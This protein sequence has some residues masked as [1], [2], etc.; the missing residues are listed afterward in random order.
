[1]YLSI[2]VSVLYKSYSPYKIEK[3]GQQ[4]IL[5]ILVDYRLVDCRLV[6]YSHWSGKFYIFVSITETKEK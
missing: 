6:N 2:Y 3:N 5:N 1:M 4:K